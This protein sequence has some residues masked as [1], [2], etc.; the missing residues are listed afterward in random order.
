MLDV[1]EAFWRNYFGRLG[2]GDECCKLKD[3]DPKRLKLA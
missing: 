1:I 3:G 2:G